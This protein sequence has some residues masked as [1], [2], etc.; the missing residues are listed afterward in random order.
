MVIFDENTMV[1]A[2]FKSSFVLCGSEYGIAP[3]DEDGN[4]SESE[5]EFVETRA[6]QE[7]WVFS[8]I[9]SENYGD[10]AMIFVYIPELD[11]ATT[12]SS[13]FIDMGLKK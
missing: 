7:C 13:S 11:Y 12:V 4:I 2:R 5:Y 3:S 9:F 8:G 6:G 1:R 10:N